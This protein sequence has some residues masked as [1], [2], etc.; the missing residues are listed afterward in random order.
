MIITATSYPTLY[1]CAAEMMYDQGFSSIPAEFLVDDTTEFGPLDFAGSEAR[2]SA[3]SEEDLITI[4]CG[5]DEEWPDIYERHGL[6]EED[7]ALL[8]ELFMTIGG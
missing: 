4:C 2:L 6:T 1:R 5:D 8:G 7:G 3:L